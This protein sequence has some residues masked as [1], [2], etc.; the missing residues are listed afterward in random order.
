[1][2]DP[3]G[4]AIPSV[5]PAPA[6]SGGENSTPGS[7]RLCACSVNAAGEGANMLFAAGNAERPARLRFRLLLLVPIGAWP[8]PP[9]QRGRAG[10]SAR[11]GL[12]Q[13]HPRYRPARHVFF[14]LVPGRRRERDG[15]V[16]DE[17]FIVYYDGARGKQQAVRGSILAN[18]AEFTQ[19]DHDLAFRVQRYDLVSLIRRYPQAPVLVE[20]DAVGAVDALG[21]NRDLAHCDVEPQHAVVSGVGD[22][23]RRFVLVEGEPVGAE[24]RKTSGGEQR[25]VIERRHV[26]VRCAAFRIGD[27]EDGALERVGDVEIPAAVEGQRIGNAGAGTKRDRIGAAVRVVY[28][29]LIGRAYPRDD[30]DVLEVGEIRRNTLDLGIDAGKIADVRDVNLVMNAVE[31]QPEQ[32]RF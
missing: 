20:D 9:Q 7:A 19:L 8:G 23:Q 10:S 17:Y 11:S 29:A 2:P 13:L 16:G 14:R 30:P 1:M 25:I 28:D 32:R 6:R 21:K 3:R 22:E 26:A 5:R 24:G 27:L 4:L 31:F 15:E 12:R 18:S